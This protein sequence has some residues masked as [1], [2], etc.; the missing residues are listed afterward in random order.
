MIK[1]K[2]KL[3]EEIKFGNS[4]EIF[5]NGHKAGVIGEVRNYAINKPG[6]RKIEIICDNGLLQ[7]IRFRFLA[8]SW[9]EQGPQ[10]F[11][12]T[13]IFHWPQEVINAAIWHEVGH[14]HYEHHLKN[15]YRDQPELRT[16]RKECIMS[17]IIPPEE[18][19]ADIFAVERVGK[20]PVI[21]CLEILLNSRPSGHRRS[22]NELGKKELSL[23]IEE[24]K[25]MT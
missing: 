25:K 16:R 10:I 3:L 11:L 1:N 20:K 14:I 13:D 7:N 2:F 22:L 17:G 24:I 18:S 19:Q 15:V 6:Y 8:V 4:Y 9:N 21:D 12:H 5:W 23:R